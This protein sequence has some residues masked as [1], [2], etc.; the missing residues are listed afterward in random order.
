MMIT[1]LP[2]RQK[3]HGF[4]MIELIVVLLVVGVM[5]IFFAYS[6][7]G[8]SDDAKANLSKTALASDMPRGIFS[9]LS[10][11]N[12]PS[13]GTDLTS[14]IAERG[15]KPTTPWG[16]TWSATSQGTGS[17][18]VV[19]VTYPIGAEDGVSLA[20]LIAEDLNDASL[21]PQ[22]ESATASGNTITVKYKVM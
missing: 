19:K 16:D 20:D 22:I 9:Y 11:A 7:M 8:S 17:G 13:S 6:L 1:S 21:Y 14:E 18:A 2:I 15:V 10:M 5:A 4:T 3:Q 12:I